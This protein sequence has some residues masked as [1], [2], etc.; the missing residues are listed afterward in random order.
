MTAGPSSS[1]EVFSFFKISADPLER[2]MGGDPAPGSQVQRVVSRT[3]VTHHPDTTTTLQSI[4]EAAALKIKLRR[5][6]R[7]DHPP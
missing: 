4:T 2:F 6:R 1:Q 3:C 5:D 7:K